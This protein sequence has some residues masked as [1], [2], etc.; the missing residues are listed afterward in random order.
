MIPLKTN[1]ASPC[2]ERSPDFS[3]ECEK[4]PRPASKNIHE[5]ISGPAK[6]IIR[7]GNW[8]LFFWK[9]LQF[10]SVTLYQSRHSCRLGKRRRERGNNL[11]NERITE[12]GS[13]S[14]LI[15]VTAVLANEA[16]W[17]F[18][19]SPLHGQIK[20]IPIML[21]RIALQKA[22]FHPLMT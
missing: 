16:F 6:Q 2:A 19:I 3:G 14:R 5:E 22:T 18:S 7:W 11:T 10:E 20:F 1:Y 17:R 21:K 13:N 12:W 4:K 8:V 9:Q 15:S